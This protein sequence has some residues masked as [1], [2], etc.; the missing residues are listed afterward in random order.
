M[1]D[2]ILVQY[3]G[4]LAAL[5]GCKSEVLQV[6]DVGEVLRQV[7]W[8]HGAKAYKLAKAMLIAVDGKSISLADGFKTKLSGC[9][10]VMFLPVCGGG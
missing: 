8:A 7:K 6:A 3:R 4:E 2:T 10:E 1:S 9:G 5:T